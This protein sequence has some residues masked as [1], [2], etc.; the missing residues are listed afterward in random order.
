MAQFQ[1]QMMDV[2]DEYED[3]VKAH[4]THAVHEHCSSSEMD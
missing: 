4:V 3:F 1:P 2:L